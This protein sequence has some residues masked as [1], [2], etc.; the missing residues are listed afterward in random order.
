M[1]VF[2]KDGVTVKDPTVAEA[3]ELRSRGFRVEKVR[4]EVV[5]PAEP[6]PAP[7]K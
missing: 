7:S 5:K 6:K 4:A 1:A 2:V 3:A